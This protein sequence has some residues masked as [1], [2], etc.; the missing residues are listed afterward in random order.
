M[1][2]EHSGL[3]EVFRRRGLGAS[4][5]FGARPAVI[6]VDYSLGFT[7]PASPLGSDY[8]AELGCTGRLLSVMRARG[9]PVAFTTVSYPEGPHA[10]EHFLNKVPSLALLKD[11]DRWTE[12]DPRLEVQSGEPVWVK[13]FAS[14]FFGP[15]L[16]TWLQSHGADT[17]IVCGATTS[18]CVRATV[19]DGLQYGYRVI[20]P[21]ECVGDRAPGPHEASLFD[22]N[23][24]YAD[25]LGLEEV[26]THLNALPQPGTSRISSPGAAMNSEH[27]A[28]EPAQAQKAPKTPPPG[29]GPLSGLRVIEMGSLLAGP[30]VGQLL[31][32]FGAE[33]I[34]IEP[35]KVGD[36]MRAWGRIKPQGRSLWFP[37]IAR[38]KKSVT[39]DLRQEAG[40]ALAREMIVGADILVE[41]FRPGTLEKWGL[42]PDELHKLNP[43]L[44]MV[45][46]SGYGQTGPYSSRAGFGSI[47]EAVG[48]LRALSGE[49]GQPPVRVG[50][51]IGD[52]LAGTLGA[53]GAM[54]A[55]FGRLKSGV[56]QVVDIS[57]YE[58]VLTYMES[59]IPEYALSGQV[60]ERSGSVLPGIAPSNIYPAL[61]EGGEPG[62]WVVI[63]ANGDNVF[64]RLV[65][66]MRKPGLADHADYCSHEARGRNMGTLDALIA[67]WTSGLRVSEVVTRLEAAGVPA[68]KMY[69][70]RDMLADPHFA[71]RGNIVTLPH[72]QLGDF[73][74]QGVVPRL[75]ETPGSV[76]TLG[77]EL[78]Q[79][80]A[81]IYGELLGKSAEQLAELEAAGVI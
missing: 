17:L 37:V 53:L 46:V 67:A 49:P 33:V 47:G 50:I 32:D 68:S 30:F 13:L 26:L 27:T 5:G 43:R 54:M 70:A 52:M 1:T 16:H 3:Q 74:M 80:N 22:I 21:R 9:L 19:V 8:S 75:S 10:A 58:A 66:E 64:R 23:A 72:P 79:H 6:V 42:G 71:A 76:R 11:G 55:L 4:V 25:V 18:G 15:P 12:I 40:Q 65:A 39:L 62:E 57:L 34:K 31:G 7:D 14:S 60:R 73:P 48:G 38:N 2:G 45:R 35:P 59:M 51:S 56:G 77:P 28:T 36:P 20:V 29:P 44:V 78:G 81:E 61:G 41:N 24:K 69:T 63:G